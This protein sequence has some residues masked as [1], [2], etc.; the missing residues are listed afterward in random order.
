MADSQPLN[1]NRGFQAIPK[2]KGADFSASLDMIPT[3]SAGFAATGP[4][5]LT[6]HKPAPS[7]MVSV[8]H[9]TSGVEPAPPDPGPVLPRPPVMSAAKEAELR[10]LG[11]AQGLAQG[12]AEAQA[13]LAEA[14]QQ[15]RSTAQILAK[16][17]RLVSD[18]PAETATELMQALDQAVSR[19]A[20]DRAGIAIGSHPDAFAA[21]LAKLAER[22]TRKS[23]DLAVRLHPDDLAAVGAILTQSCPPD[24]AALAQA[25]MEADQKL[26]RGDVMIAAPGV[27]LS[28]LLDPKD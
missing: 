22:I 3:A 10:A 7:K 24:L 2:P 18:P 12:R 6:R 23:E 15:A 4:S 9:L 5:G 21:R 26:A 11:H 27:A 19:L 20:S 13:E 14:L 28:D 1:L 8:E 17:L 25:R 16:A